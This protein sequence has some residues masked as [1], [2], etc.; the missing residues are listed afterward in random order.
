MDVEEWMG[1]VSGECDEQQIGRCIEDQ[2]K[3]QRPERGLV[4]GDQSC[5]IDST[6][7]G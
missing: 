7:P 5:N 2:S 1:Q 4:S 3:Q 6:Y